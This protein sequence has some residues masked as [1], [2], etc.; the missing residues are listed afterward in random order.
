MT[1]S[2]SS[3]ND[4][5]LAF[6]A[7]FV[8]ME[9]LQIVLS[10]FDSQDFFPLEEISPP[11]DVETPVESSIL[12][13]PSSLVGSSSPVRM[14]PKMTSTS[15]APAMTQAAI[16]QLIA[17]G[18]AAALEAQATTIENTNNPNR[19][20]RP[21][22]TPI[23]KRGNYKEFISCQPFYLNVL[24]SNMVPNSEKLME[25]FIRGLPRSIKGNVIASKPHT[26]EEAITITQRLMEQGGVRGGGSVVGMM[27][28]RSGGGD[29]D[30]YKVVVPAVDG[31]EGE[32]GGEWCG[33]S[34]R[35]GDKECFWFWPEDSP[36]NF[37]GGGGGGGRRQEGRRVAE[38][39]RGEEGF[40]CVLYVLLK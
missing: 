20:T 27:V 11:K 1:P 37:F 17:D 33:G 14:P 7:I 29:N 36:E 19:N 28:L 3:G 30:G 25:V 34:S 8:K 18:I 16:R 23:A 32:G 15:A 26:L 12:V 10:L 21:R 38:N 35:S 5:Q 40:V 31:D 22:E 24:C 6:A 39:N 2:M 4:S 9:V 13:S